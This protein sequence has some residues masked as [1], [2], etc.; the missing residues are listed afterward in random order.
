MSGQRD[1]LAHLG[2]VP[3]DEIRGMRAPQIAAGSDEQFEMMKKAGFFYDNT[4]IADPGPDGEPYWPQTL[5]YRVSWPCLDENCPQSSFP[6][7]WEIPI[8]LFHGAQKIGAERRRSS[9]IR[10]AVQWNSSASDIYNLLM[11]NFERAYYT[12]RAPYLLTLNADFLQLNE[13]KAAMQALKR[14]VYKSCCTFAEM[15]T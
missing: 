10:G 15:R 12:N 11:D 4:L 3:E 13:G 1:I 6:G 9:M 7:I 5:D 14:F 8:N 2:N